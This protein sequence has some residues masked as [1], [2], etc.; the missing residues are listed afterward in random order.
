MT[1]NRK[2]KY[3]KRLRNHYE[4]ARAE[5]WHL[6]WLREMSHADQRIIADDLDDFTMENSLMWWARNEF[7]FQCPDSVMRWRV[8]FWNYSGFAPRIGYSRQL[9]RYAFH[10]PFWDE[11]LFEYEPY[12]A[13]NSNEPQMD[14]RKRP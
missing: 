7:F 5:P 1:R 14:V 3:V 2:V 10:S 4:F 13:E 11:E 8:I 9:K 12:A 6:A